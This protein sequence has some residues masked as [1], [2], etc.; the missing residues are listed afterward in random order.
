MTKIGFIFKKENV[1]LAKWELERNL[2]S[3]EVVS[4]SEKLVI[5]KISEI[6]F[7]K[8][9]NAQTFPFG[10]IDRIVQ[11]Y[12]HASLNKFMDDIASNFFVD[13]I[14][15]AWLVDNVELETCTLL[16]KQILKLARKY[17]KKIETNNIARTLSLGDLQ[18]S[19]NI[20]E[21]VFLK[22]ENE[23]ILGRTIKFLNPFYFKE[24]DETRPGRMFTHGTSPKLAKVL[25]NLIKNKTGTVVDPFCGT[26]T[27]LLELLRQGYDVIGIDN[28][29]KVLS[30]ARKNI[31]D[32]FKNNNLCEKRNYTL[33]NSKFENVE[34][35]A[36]AS[37]FEP[38]MGPFLK[39]IPSPTVAKAIL[40][41]LNFLY[42]K[43]FQSLHQN[44]EGDGEIICIL[45]SIPSKLQVH[46]LNF[47]LI[48]QD[49]FKLSRSKLNS[50]N[51][52]DY[53]SKKGNR[54]K[55]KIF[56]LEKINF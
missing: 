9:V 48:F 56:I 44:L 11:I 18:K 39:K 12:E 2:V 51:P 7:E 8:I 1:N 23:I 52:I 15:F 32:Y 31:K 21:V 14:E 22:R 28:D 26:G 49:K 6:D 25:V 10:A 46:E 38:Y 37:V 20:V 43:T 53:E 50:Q 54:I 5:A 45:P 36:T 16:S 19:E 40:K 41:E 33:I 4:E 55:R 47:D 35:K 27:I 24:L 30:L 34:F 42:Q 13:S 17:F 3:F 29:S